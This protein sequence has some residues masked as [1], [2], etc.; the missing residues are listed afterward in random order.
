MKKLCVFMVLFAAGM[1]VLKGSALCF[2]IKDASTV[3]KVRMTSAWSD[4]HLDVIE[5]SDVFDIYEID[6]M[7]DPAR[8]SNIHID[9]SVSHAISGFA[10]HAAEPAIPRFLYSVTDRYTLVTILLLFSAVAGIFALYQDRKKRSDITQYSRIKFGGKNPLLFKS[11]G[12]TNACVNDSAGLAKKE[13][14]KQVIGGMTPCTPNGE[15]SYPEQGEK[16][17]KVQTKTTQDVPIM[18]NKLEKEWAPNTSRSKVGTK[19]VKRTVARKSAK[20]TA[21]GMV[22]EVIRRSRKGVNMAALRKK[23]GFD[24]K[25]IRNIVYRLKKQEKIRS[26]LKGVYIKA[27]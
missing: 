4:G 11:A 10:A 18:I 21:T 15:A 26:V 19:G 20:V 12:Q 22:F 3:K 1:F 16:G 8:G 9:L 7:A 14:T 24:E 25:K 27:N 2:L 23:T 5:D 13:V 6:R 17:P